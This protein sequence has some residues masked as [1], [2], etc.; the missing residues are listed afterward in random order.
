[1]HSKKFLDLF[2]STLLAINSEKGNDID[3]TIPI[4]SFDE[5]PN[6]LLLA[7]KH[8]VGKTVISK[9]GDP[10]KVLEISSDPEKK[11]LRFINY[12]PLS[13]K[14]FYRLTKMSQDIVG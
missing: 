14:D 11:T 1:M 10:D 6:S 5:L 4:S 12:F 2:F 8:N 3:I 7:Q 13:S 9:P